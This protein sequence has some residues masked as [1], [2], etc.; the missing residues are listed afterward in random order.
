MSSIPIH[1]CSLNLG[2]KLE[3]YQAVR[4]TATQADW[5]AAEIDNANGLIQQRNAFALQE[6]STIARPFIE[7]LQ[8]NNFKIIRCKDGAPDAGFDAAIALDKDRFT[9]ITNNSR[10][11]LMYNERRA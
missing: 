11:L 3:D 7:A 1:F 9:N 4:P 5:I 2:S 10:R 8:N 6:V